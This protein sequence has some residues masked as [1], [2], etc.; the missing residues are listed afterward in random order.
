[1]NLQHSIQEK[2]GNEKRTLLEKNHQKE[3]DTLKVRSQGLLLF[4]SKAYHLNLQHLIQEEKKTMKKE[5]FLRKI[6]KKS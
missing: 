5:L 1:L 3:L 4:L 6:I 2:K